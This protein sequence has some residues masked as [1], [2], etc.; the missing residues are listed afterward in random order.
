[1]SCRWCSLVLST[2]CVLLWLLTIALCFDVFRIYIFWLM[3]AHLPPG[4]LFSLGLLLRSS[5]HRLF[6]GPFTHTE[7]AFTHALDA[8]RFLHSSA[9]MHNGFYTR[10]TEPISHK[11][12]CTQRLLHTE[13][14]THTVYSLHT[15]DHKS[16]Y[17]HLLWHTQKKAFTHTFHKQRLLRT[18]PLLLPTRTRRAWAGLSHG[19]RWDIK[20]TLPKMGRGAWEPHVPNAARLQGWTQ[21]LWGTAVS[22]DK[23]RMFPWRVMSLYRNFQC[24]MSP[25]NVAQSYTILYIKTTRFFVECF[26]R[27]HCLRHS[28]C[29]S[30][31]HLLY[32]NIID[33]DINIRQLQTFAMG[34]TRIGKS[35]QKHQLIKTKQKIM[36]F[37]WGPTKLDSSETVC[38]Q[39]AHSNH[40]KK[41]GLYL[42][43]VAQ[44]Q[45]LLLASD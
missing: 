13:A 37:L 10:S 6:G 21:R 43:A 14:L 5:R 35:Q 2:P 28:Q 16:L 15:K 38:H 39:V 17:T 3:I 1:M 34:P 31:G 40:C 29:G 32:K 9:F 45:Q 4:M 27:D 20:I 19:G 36:V 42:I 22:A 12:F 26:F 23:P 24:N 44:I 30:M 25:K 41:I 8:Q 18:G 7:E 11:G 33:E